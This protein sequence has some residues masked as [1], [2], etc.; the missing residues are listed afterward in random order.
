MKEKTTNPD[1][2]PTNTHTHTQTINQSINQSMTL[3]GRAGTQPLSQ[4]WRSGGRRTSSYRRALARGKPLSQKTKAM[5]Q[6]HHVV[7]IL[8]A[9]QPFLK[10]RKQPTHG[11]EGWRKSW[12]STKHTWNSKPQIL[13]SVI[14]TK[15]LWEEGSG[16][17]E[18]RGPAP[19][20]SQSPPTLWWPSTNVRTQILLAPCWLWLN[21]LTSKNPMQ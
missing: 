6:K 17:N 21:G 9:S 13:N 18:A 10:A 8:S 4:N 20:H 12:K 16:Q 5:N 15:A 7:S 19:R 14:N 2:W 3:A 11:G 1:L